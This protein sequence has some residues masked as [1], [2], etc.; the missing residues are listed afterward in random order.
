MTNY[1]QEAPRMNIRG[2]TLIEIVIVIILLA[3]TSSVAAPKF[4]NISSNAK[5]ES[6]SHIAANLRTSIDL[7]YYKALVLDLDKKCYSRAGNKK[8]F[9]AEIEGYYTCNGYPVAFIN[10]IERLISLSSQYTTSNFKKKYRG[11]KASREAGLFRVMIISAID[12]FTRNADDIDG[13]YCQ[14]IYQPNS[15][16]QIVVL[17]SGC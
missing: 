3:I 2:F 12:T 8:D 1:L 5:K 16:K 9:S 6:I 4:I 14:V 15:L 10:S 17:D 11:G 7:I 13:P